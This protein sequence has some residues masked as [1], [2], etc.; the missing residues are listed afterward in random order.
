[1]TRRSGRRFVRRGRASVSGVLFVAVTELLEE[2]DRV[3]AR[4]SDLRGE[5]HAL[6]AEAAQTRRRSQ[7]A[8]LELDATAILHSLKR[9][10]V[11]LLAWNGVAPTAREMT[12]WMDGIDSDIAGVEERLASLRPRS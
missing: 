1:M 7:I 3:R 12:Q 4:A 10:G 9:F 6:Q 8:R 5:A 11:T 2:V